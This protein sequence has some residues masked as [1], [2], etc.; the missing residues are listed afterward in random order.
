MDPWTPVPTAVGVV[1][2][3]DVHTGAGAV[4]LTASLRQA[5]RAMHKEVLPCPEAETDWR[6]EPQGGALET[7]SR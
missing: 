6:P 7:R 4:Q 3:E 2:V 1:D 5:Q